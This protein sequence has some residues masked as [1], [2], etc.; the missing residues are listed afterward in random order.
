MVA[1]LHRCGV[2]KLKIEGEGGR[3]R[4]GEIK[5]DTVDPH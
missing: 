3:E 4:G 5:R 2:Y 1:S